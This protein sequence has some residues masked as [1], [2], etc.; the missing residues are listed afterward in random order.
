MEPGTIP[1]AAPLDLSLPLRSVSPRSPRVDLDDLTSSPMSSRLEDKTI[2]SVLPGLPISSPMASSFRSSFSQESSADSISTFSTGPSTPRTPNAKCEVDD[3]LKVDWSYIS[4]VHVPRTL[5]R[6]S[7]PL[8]DEDVKRVKLPGLQHLL[9]SPEDTQRYIAPLKPKHRLQILSSSPEPKSEYVFSRRPSMLP[10]EDPITQSLNFLRR[11]T[12]KSKGLLPQIEGLSEPSLDISLDFTNK[13]HRAEHHS[14]P[15]RYSYCFQSRQESSSPPR[16]IVKKERAK[17]KNGPHCNIKYSLEEKD[18]MRYQ[19]H[20]MKHSWNTITK[21]FGAKFPMVEGFKREQQGVQGIL[22]RENQNIPDIVPG[23]N[24]LRFLPN[25]HVASISKKV[26][27]QGND[28]RKYGLVYLYPERA[29]G[30]SWV[31]PEDRREAAELNKERVL[32]RAQ[33]RRDAMKRGAWV[34]KFE[35]GICACC[36]K[37]DQ[38]R[39][40]RKRA[41]PPIPSLTASFEWPKI[42]KL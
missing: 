20:E 2:E 17:S 39:D 18:F 40:T 8:E 42:A 26:R 10:G 30:Y 22:Y 24:E 28:K 11:E 31:S 41:A 7:E 9:E 35:D 27:E 19:K 33:A 1:R 13:F 3:M 36:V 29:M 32:Q 12:D 25:G 6:K 5:K 38:E 21:L 15:E 34:E 37:D 16:E 4:A 14:P 23:R